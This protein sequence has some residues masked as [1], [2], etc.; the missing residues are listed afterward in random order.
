MLVYLSSHF[1]YRSFPLSL[2]LYWQIVEVAIVTDKGTTRRRGFVFV[3][4]TTEDAVDKITEI[5]FHTIEGAKVG[6]GE[7]PPTH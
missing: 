3:T 1:L 2:S 5:S 6:H 4:Y 7:T